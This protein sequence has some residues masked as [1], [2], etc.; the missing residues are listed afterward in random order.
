MSVSIAQSIQAYAVTGISRGHITDSV[1]VTNDANAPIIGSA[2][3]LQFLLTDG[4]G[5]PVPFQRTDPPITDATGPIQKGGSFERD[6]H[7]DTGPLDASQQYTLSCK[8]DDDTDAATLSFSP[9]F[10][11]VPGQQPFSKS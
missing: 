2:G 5:N 11:G 1:T 4:G 8:F 7:F 10:L 6:A 3:G 9:L